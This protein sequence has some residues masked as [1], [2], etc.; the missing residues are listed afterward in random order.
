MFSGNTPISLSAIA[1]VEDEGPKRASS[2]ARQVC[3]K[4]VGSMTLHEGEASLKVE[5][6]EG[7][8]RKGASERNVPSEA[9]PS[10][11]QG[12][13]EGGRAGPHLIRQG[14]PGGGEGAS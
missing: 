9:P 10:T 2:A 8:L 6:G 14:S 12:P 7:R 5:G 3:G 1:E 4:Q 13:K 11:T